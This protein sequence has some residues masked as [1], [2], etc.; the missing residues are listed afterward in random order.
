MRENHRKSP[1]LVRDR[2]RSRTVQPAFTCV[3]ECLGLGGF[4]FWFGGLGFSEG[5]FREELK[6]S[7]SLRNIVAYLLRV[8]FQQ[9]INKEDFF[10]FFFLFFFGLFGCVF[11]FPLMSRIKLLKVFY[12][13][14]RWSLW[15]RCCTG[16]LIL[17][18]S[19]LTPPQT[20]RLIQDES[21][22]QKHFWYSCG[23][24]ISWSGSELYPGK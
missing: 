6:N 9:F 22:L 23:G 11:F 2:V 13:G 7:E 16:S 20:N 5:S 3:H 21:K 4:C 17:G 8:Y 10:F 18:R 15:L 12:E 24:G 19:F 1:L 14:R